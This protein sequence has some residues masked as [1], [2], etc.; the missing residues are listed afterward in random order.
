M[1]HCS[2]SGGPA[3]DLYDALTPLVNWVEKGT[4]PDTIV[5]KAGATTPWPGRTRPLCTYPQ[6]ARYLGSGSIDD[7]VNFACR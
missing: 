1:N 7:A 3:T 5:A 2:N 6:Q 4:A